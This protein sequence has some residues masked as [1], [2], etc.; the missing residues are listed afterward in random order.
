MLSRTARLVLKTAGGKS[1]IRFDLKTTTPLEGYG[2]LLQN[3]RVLPSK[4]RRLCGDVGE[5]AAPPKHQAFRPKGPKP[6]AFSSKGPNLWCMMSP[7]P[8]PQSAGHFRLKAQFLT[9]FARSS[10]QGA[11]LAKPSGEEPTMSPRMV[12]VSTSGRQAPRSAEVARMVASL[13]RPS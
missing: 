11:M 1:P 10:L 6:W 3:I 2:L 5:G 4:V 7:R 12:I 13:R 8:P 9:P